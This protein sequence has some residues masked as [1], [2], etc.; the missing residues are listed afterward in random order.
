MK[1]QSKGGLFLGILIFVA[2]L[3]LLVYAKV[4]YPAP[5]YEYIY[6]GDPRYTGEVIDAYEDRV[7]GWEVQRI[8]VDDHGNPGW[9][10]TLYGDAGVFVV[11]GAL[12]FMAVLGP[13]T[14]EPE[15]DSYI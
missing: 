13:R 14:R 7:S 9:V 1:G 12:I 2:C 3:S 15:F 10:M 8:L 5:I 4:A 6:P 11:I